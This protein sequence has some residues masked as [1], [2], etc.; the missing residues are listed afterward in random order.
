MVGA[1]VGVPADRE[2]GTA[3]P[4]EGQC[5]A[6]HLHGHGGD[7]ALHGD[8]EERLQVARLRGGAGAVQ[9]LVVDARLDRADQAGALPGGAQPG[10]D[11]VGG[12][13]LAGGTG[14]AEYGQRGGRV[15]VDE[16][17]HLADRRAGIVDDQGGQPGPG[18]ERRAGRIGE[19]RDRAGRGG[20]TGEPGAVGPR[21]RQ[22]GEEIARTDRVAGHGDPGDAR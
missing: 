17:G 18:R 11:E 3:D 14:D 1:E 7:P 19:H 16:R 22:R 9:Y 12:G 5:V 6:G 8:G 2:P 10:L 20:G 13:R 21:T 4:P 15:A